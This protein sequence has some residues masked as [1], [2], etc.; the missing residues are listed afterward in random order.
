[1]KLY[2][3][4]EFGE[5]LDLAIHLQD[6]ENHEVVLG[7]TNPDYEKIGEGIVKKDTKWWNYLN[8]GWIF[9]FDGCEDG[10]L[11]DWLRSKGELVF[12]GSEQGD[13]L[14]NDRQLGQKLFKAAGFK[15]PMSK[16]FKDLDV[17]LDF[18]KKNSD[19]RWVLKQNGNAP[20]SLNHMGKFDSNEDMVFHLEGLK[21]S[22][23][24]AHMGK[25][26]FDLME[27]VE[28]LEVAASAFFN[29]KEYMQNKDGKIVGYLNF[30]EKKEAN[31]NTGETT[32]EMGTTFIGVTEDNK[33]FADILLRD[34]IVEAL[35]AI[36]FR[37]VFDIN[38]IKTKDGIV[39]LEPTC[40]F[41]VP[42]TSYEF[43]VGLDN[44]GETIEVVARGQNKPIHVRQGIGMVMCIVSKPY[45]VEADMDEEATSLG[46]KLWILD[47]GKPINDFTEE[48]KRNIHLQNFYND[49]SGDYLV[50]TKNGY[51]LTVTGTGKDISSTRE[52]LIQYIKDNLYISGM[53]YR[54]DIGKRVEE[55]YGTKSKTAAEVKVQDKLEEQKQSY[56]TKIAELKSAMKDAL[57]APN[58]RAAK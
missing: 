54:T 43:L 3:H 6:I 56:E 12:G 11:Q 24:E 51:L 52:N 13:K 35:K 57:Y 8:Q 49:D 42:S 44:V 7:V 50:A 30:E 36:K 19:R 22:W 37:G 41:G 31:G 10:N 55:Y 26:D 17:A 40:R 5:L 46:E 18:I 39:A 27:V 23:N 29:G 20:K 48:K 38:C 21:K 28:G 2:I 14:E 9:V 4:S 32:G 33:L 47:S 25:V 1:M 34:K 58:D 45:P 16:N 15:Q 53:K